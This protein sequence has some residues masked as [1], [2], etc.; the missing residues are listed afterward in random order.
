MTHAGLGQLAVCGAL[1][2]SSTVA[3]AQE[4]LSGRPTDASGA[5]G[6]SYG[7]ADV[8]HYDSASGRARVHYALGGTHAP[9]SASTLE[10]GIPD[11]VVVAAQAA[12]DAFA[13]Y[14]ELGYRPPLSDGDSPCASNGDSDAVDIYLLHFAAADGQAVSAHCDDGV[15]QRCAGF[16]LVENDFRSG[17]YADSAEGLRTVVPHELFHL[18]QNA[19]DSGVERWWAEGSAQ[20]AAQQVYPELHDLERF[21]PAYFDNPWRPL[22]VPPSGPIT[23]FL[24]ATAIWPVFLSERFGVEIVREIHERFADNRAGVF[25]TTAEVLERHD[26]S[27]PDEYLQFAAYNAATGERAPDAGGYQHAVDYPPVELMPLAFEPGDELAETAA[28]LNAFYY[29]LSASTPLRL[30]L[31][32]PGARAA[33]LLLP[34]VNGK[35]ELSEQVALPTTLQGDGI[36]VVTGQSLE[37]TDAPFTLR[38]VDPATADGP[39]AHDREPGASGCAVVRSPRAAAPELALPLGIASML[40][41]GVGLRRHRSRKD[42]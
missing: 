31:A 7:S 20:W 25:P 41:F 17:G 23:D 37:R 10:P 36:V 22:N 42:A 24:Y 8:S 18:V 12:D 35:A 16:V 5:A 26:S 33:G 11:A 9:P 3:R 30:E 32:Q 39:G 2:L 40:L 19:Y 6:L 1:I 27:L 14:D 34:L 29:A 13:K 28:G 21:L 15:P 4:C 38:A